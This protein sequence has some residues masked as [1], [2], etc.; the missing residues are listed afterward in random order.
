M[1]HLTQDTPAPAE[2][3]SGAVAQA[4]WPASADLDPGRWC[5][6]H[7][8]VE[9]SPGWRAALLFRD[10]LRASPG[11]RRRLPGDRRSEW[12][13]KYATATIADYGDAKEP[14]SSDQGDFIEME[15]WATDTD[16]HPWT[17][18]PRQPCVEV[19]SSPPRPAARSTSKLAVHHHHGGSGEQHANRHG[20]LGADNAGPRGC[21]QPDEA[22]SCPAALPR[23][24]PTPCAR[25]L[26][27]GSLGMPSV[28][29]KNREMKSYSA[30]AAVT[31]RP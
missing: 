6:V 15:R 14:L 22:S 7:L 28:G 2:P 30:A 1:P 4:K 11:P 12:P 17:T 10:W 3:G 8:R 5:N 13:P 27:T 23:T 21:L 24:A 26:V 25:L 9:G 19:L 18:H 16:W 31:M 20:Y 29:A